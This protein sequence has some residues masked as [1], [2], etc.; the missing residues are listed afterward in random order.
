MLAV[1]HATAPG[2]WGRDDARIRAEFGAGLFVVAEAVTTSYGGKREPIALDPALAA[3]AAA[4]AATSGDAEDRLRAALAAANARMA[5]LRRA[6][7]TPERLAEH[8]VTV[9]G[10]VIE[11]G[12]ATIAQVGTMRAYL[13]RGDD[14]AVV[15]ADHGAPPSSL[16]GWDG[17][18]IAAATVE[19]AA[20]DRL[21]L[22]SAGAWR[23][24]DAW[25]RAVLAADDD[26]A[27]LAAD[28]AA[29]TRDMASVLVLAA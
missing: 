9:V 26:L 7:R 28:A 13:A 21:V 27:R 11:G 16:L 18:A 15:V 6:D 1:A 3:Y 14:I 2:P 22:C 25:L 10:A 19:L 4:L 17:Y 23:A 29:R 8:G 12:R 24:G 20:G 5:E